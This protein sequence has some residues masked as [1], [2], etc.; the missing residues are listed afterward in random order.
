MSDLN[1]DAVENDDVTGGDG[2]DVDGGADKGAGFKAITSQEDFD[3]A[4]ARRVARERNKYKDYD[5]LKAKAQEFERLEAEKGSDIE[6]LTRRAEK[7]ERELASLTD[8]LTKAE[9]LELVRDIADELGLPKKL[10]K[11]VQGDSEEDIRADIEDLLDGLPKSEKKD[12]AEDEGG[13]KKPPTQTPKAR[14]TFTATGDESDSGLELS[15]DDILKDL[16]R[17]GGVG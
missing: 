3:K 16:P 6:K 4:V 17:G 9:R 10:V 11:R 15:A 12:D 1:V 2:G 5:D 8:K 13:K 14:M 7:A